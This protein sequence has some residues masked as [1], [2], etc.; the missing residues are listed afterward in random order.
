MYTVQGLQESFLLTF[1]IKF[2]QY[3][4]A[5]DSTTRLL[6]NGKKW[7]VNNCEL[8]ELSHLLSIMWLNAV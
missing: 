5:Y 3:Y 8:S 1:H 6:R 4:Q 2:H 7:N